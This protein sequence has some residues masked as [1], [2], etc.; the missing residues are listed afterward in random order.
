MEH[1]SV[2]GNNAV[3]KTSIP[4]RVI[5]A[6]TPFATQEQLGLKLISFSHIC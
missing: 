5:T 2:L 6:R 3:I 4:A 1:S